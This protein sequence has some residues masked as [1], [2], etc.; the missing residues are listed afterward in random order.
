MM[1]TFQLVI[2]MEVKLELRDAHCKLFA[3]DVY[4]SLSYEIIQKGGG[5]VLKRTVGGGVVLL[6]TLLCLIIV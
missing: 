6:F 2:L 5:V 1:V 4:T 3:N